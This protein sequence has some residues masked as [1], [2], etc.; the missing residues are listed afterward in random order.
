MSEIKYEITL[1]CAKMSAQITVAPCILF[2]QNSWIYAGSSIKKIGVLSRSALALRSPRR[3]SAVEG[4]GWAKPPSAR[5]AEH[6]PQI[7]R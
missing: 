7:R 6:L 3:G 4:S 1:Y 2:L 5:F